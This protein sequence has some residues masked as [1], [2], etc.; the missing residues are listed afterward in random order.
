MHVRAVGALGCVQLLQLLGSAIA[1]PIDQQPLK[2]ASSE[3][4]QTVREEYAGSLLEF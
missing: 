3:D 2:Y 1:S 4:V